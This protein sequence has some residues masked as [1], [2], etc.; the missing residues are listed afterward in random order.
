ML[1]I[2]GMAKRQLISKLIDVFTKYTIFCSKFKNANCSI[3]RGELFREL[4]QTEE[5]LS[6]A[7]ILQEQDAQLERPQ[8][9]VGAIARLAD[10]ERRASMENQLQT[11]IR[12]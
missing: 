3:L 8:W 1:Y 9:L 10:Y 7:R 4:R 2:K 6:R 5:Y 11:A 12:A